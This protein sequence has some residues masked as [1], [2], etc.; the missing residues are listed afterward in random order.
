MQLVA[1]GTSRNLLICK[2]RVQLEQSFFLFIFL[3]LE[4]RVL[5]VELCGLPHWASKNIHGTT[6][7]ERK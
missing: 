7:T 3:F 4:S 1:C 2:D 6:K 5:M